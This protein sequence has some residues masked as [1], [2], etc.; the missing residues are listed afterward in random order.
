MLSLVLSLLV[1]CEPPPPPIPGEV[2]RSGETIKVVNGKNVTQGMVDAQLEQLP[3]NVRDQVVARG[4]MDQVKEQV[5]TGELLYQESVKLKLHEDAKVKTQ[6]A[7]AE[8]NALA[9]ALLERTV[10]ARSTD[11]AIQKWYSEHE[12]QFARPQAKARHI[13]VKDKAEADKIL[14]EVKAGG[15]FAKIAIEKSTDKGS[16]KEG[17]DLGWFE[18]GRMVPEFGDAVFAA[19]KGALLGPIETKFGFHVIE[20]QDKRDAVPVDEVKDKIKSQLR[21][22]V[23]ESYIEELK[24]GATI[25][26]PGAAAPGAEVKPAADA[27]PATGSKPGDA[28][29]AGG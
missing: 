24:K 11:E 6:L 21:N 22:E 16:G 19:E 1:A 28:K 2:E 9:S 27:A 8:R 26:E 25:T 14:A 15:D 5:I 29:P 18:K 10:E 4:Q 3:A 17:G 13:L 12:V 23:V 20:V 7:L